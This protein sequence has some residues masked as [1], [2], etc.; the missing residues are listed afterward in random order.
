[1]PNHG[2]LEIDCLH[3]SSKASLLAKLQGIKSWVLREAGRFPAVGY[4]RAQF[5]STFDDPIC[6]YQLAAALSRTKGHHCLKCGS[7]RSGDPAGRSVMHVHS[8][9]RLREP[10]IRGGRPDSDPASPAELCAQFCCVARSSESRVMHVHSFFRCGSPL[11]RRG[12]SRYAQLFPTRNLAVPYQTD[13][14]SCGALVA[15]GLAFALHIGNPNIPT[16]FHV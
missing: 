9:I 7:Q 1:M 14:S 5:S 4:S 8:F 15:Y 13:R 12:R 2:A 16:S 10:A 11:I 3:T 6:D